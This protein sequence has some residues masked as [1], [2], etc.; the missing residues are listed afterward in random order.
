MVQHY[1]TGAQLDRGYYWGDSSSSVSSPFVP[2]TGT[3]EIDRDR[4]IERDK[5]SKFEKIGLEVGTL[6]TG[7]ND[8]Y[9]DSYNKVEAHL[10]I[11][12][13]DGIPPEDY[14]KLLYYIRQCDKHSRYIRALP[15][16]REDPVLDSCGYSLLETVKNRE[17][18]EED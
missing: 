17:K 10:L 9:G 1:T 12:W 5:L 13:P 2:V 18:L 3:I 6:V 16:D 14:G 15:G 7:K 4:F 8:K 11:E